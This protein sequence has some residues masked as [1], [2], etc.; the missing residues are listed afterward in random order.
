[1][2]RKPVPLV[3]SDTPSPVL[4]RR[5]ARALAATFPPLGVEMQSLPGGRSAVILPAHLMEFF[6][7]DMQHRLEEWQ[8]QARKV[9]VAEQQREAELY[10]ATG[11]GR[12]EW[13]VLADTWAAEY[14]RLRDAGHGHREAFRLIRG[15]KK[16]RK[17]HPQL[18]TIELGVRDGLA[19]RRAQRYAEIIRLAQAGTARQ[20]IADTFRLPYATVQNILRRA[21]IV[22]TSGDCRT[23]AC[24]TDQGTAETTQR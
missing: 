1:M 5:Q 14:L 3:V 22:P 6:V 16:D 12:R 18:G 9:R 19:R 21:R 11:E 4:R 15:P 2:S 24:K 7:A 13:Q 10:A 8:E 20:A 23:G 17:E